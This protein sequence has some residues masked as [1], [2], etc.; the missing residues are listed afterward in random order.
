MAGLGVLSCP[1]HG[2]VCS[3]AWVSSPQGNWLPPEL[4]TPE[5]GAEAT[6][7][8]MRGHTPSFLSI[9]LGTPASPVGHG[10]GLQERVHTS[11]RDTLAATVSLL[12]R[13]RT[14]RGSG[15]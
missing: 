13:I 5:T 7:P 11:R 10:K 15:Q 1:S 6:M 9:Q 4:A 8:L 3:A 14:Y 2:P 12:E